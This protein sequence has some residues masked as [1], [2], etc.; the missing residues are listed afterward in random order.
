MRA[1]YAS[2]T[3]GTTVLDNA[4]RTPDSNPLTLTRVSDEAFCRGTHGWYAGMRGASGE[5]EC[6]TMIS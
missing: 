1:C 6:L 3:S 2:N 5:T 4:S